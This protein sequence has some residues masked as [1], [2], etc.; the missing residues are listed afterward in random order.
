MSAVEEF[1][2]EVR[3]KTGGGA[4]RALRQSGMI[5]AILYGG[6]KENIPLMV[7]PRDVEKGLQQSGFYTKIFTLKVGKD[8]EQA[9]VR[10]I[11]FHPVTDRPMHLDFWRVSKESKIHIAVPVHFVNE[12][13]CLG[14]KQGGILNIVLHSLEVTC[15]ADKI[16]E[17]LT[18]DLAGME[19][20]TIIHTDALSLPKGVSVTHPERD[21][22]LA[23][24]V[25]PRVAQEEIS[26]AEAPEE[27]TG[28]TEA[29]KK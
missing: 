18:I 9:L 20:G 21:N 27:E 3:P 28:S 14:L 22:T 6:E 8:K 13:K 4:A 23:T 10:E 15:T 12:D 29:D 7:D 25:A 19:I 17:E 24:L 26:E 5:P 2:V 1:K 11:Q 16:P